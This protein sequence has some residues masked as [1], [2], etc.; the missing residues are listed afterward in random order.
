MIGLGDEIRINHKSSAIVD[1]RFTNDGSEP[2]GS[3]PLYCAPIKLFETSL[4]RAAAF[5]GEE[6]VSLTVPA[7]YLVGSRPALPVLSVSM[8]PAD[9]LDVHLQ[10]S[11]TGHASERPAFLELFDR[12]GERTLATG[13]GLRLHGGAGRGGGADWKL[14]NPTVHT[15]VKFTARAE[16]ITPSFQKPESTTSTSWSCGQTSTTDGLMA[17]TSATK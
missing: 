11:A 13:F 5:I 1:I 4:F 8:E 9:F 15:S 7:T 17:V 14:R 10:S 12:S 6:Q 16:S 3:S 2:A